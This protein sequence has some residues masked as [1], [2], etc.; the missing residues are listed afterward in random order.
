[1]D[2]APVWATADDGT[3]TVMA[4]A[5]SRPARTSRALLME[6]P[7]AGLG[8]ANGAPPS[9]RAQM[10]RLPCRTRGAESRNLRQEHARADPHRREHELGPAVPDLERQERG[11]LAGRFVLHLGKGAADANLDGQRLCRI[12]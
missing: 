12:V 1:M 2:A 3:S 7:A 4:A 9:C 10:W 5:R 6:P 11:R 8:S